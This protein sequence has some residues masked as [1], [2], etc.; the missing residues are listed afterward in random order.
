MVAP[1]PGR[2]QDRYVGYLQLL[3]LSLP[4]LGGSP[5]ST[6]DAPERGVQGRR[7]AILETEAVDAQSFILRAC[8]PVPRGV[9]PREDGQSPF[10]LLDGPGGKAVPTQVA[11]VSRA[12]DGQADVLEV[13]ARVS[14]S[15]A[16]LQLPDV[17]PGRGRPAAPRQRFTLLRSPTPTAPGPALPATVEQLLLPRGD[18]PLRLRARDPI[19]H[20]YELNLR[21]S[22]LDAGFGGRRVLKSGRYLRQTRTYGSLVCEQPRRPKGRLASLPSPLPHL[23]G[24]HAYIT[25]YADEERVSL[26]LRIHNGHSPG[27]GK[28]Q[29]LEEPLGLVYFESLEL[30]LPAGWTALP[31]V[32]DPFWGTPRQ[33][34]D[35]VVIPLVAPMAP[36][37]DGPPAMHM[38]GPRGLFTRRLELVPCAPNQ[39]DTKRPTADAA[40]GLAFP[41]SRADL[42]CWQNLDTANFGPQRT[43]LAD[44][45]FYRH[46]D[47]HGAAGARRADSEALAALVDLLTSGAAPEG[48][49]DSESASVMGWAH[50]WFKKYQ[51]V[52][53]GFAIDTIGGARVA[54]SA[55]QA[56][57]SRLEL[58]HR[59]NTCRQPQALYDW[60][61]EPAGYRQWVDG[62]G[63]VAQKYRTNVLGSPPRQRLPCLGG[64][65]AS[66]QAKTA[67]QAG[68]RPNY[69]LGTAA[70]EGGRIE[71]S[72]GSLLAW[73]PHDGQHLAR[74]TKFAQ[75]LAWLGN[76]A[77]AKDDLLLCAELYRLM[78]HEGL[79][80]ERVALAAA[81]PERAAPGELTGQDAKADPELAGDEAAR[82]EPG[83]E[84]AAAGNAPPELTPRERKLQAKRAAKEAELE[85]RRTKRERQNTRHLDQLPA[86][87]GPPPLPVYEL[88][89]LARERRQ[90]GAQVGRELAWGLDAMCAAYSLGTPD[91]RRGSAG[92]FQRMGSVLPGLAMPNGLIQR[93]VSRKFFP[94]PDHAGAQ[95]FEALLL[96]HGM[97]CLDASVFDTVAANHSEALRT[98]ALRAVDYLFFGPPWQLSAK[99]DKRGPARAFA[100]APADAREPAYGPHESGADWALPE[101][102]VAPEVETLYGYEALAWAAQLSGP[103]QG[104]ALQNR[105]LLRALKYG[106]GAAE[107]QALA[108]TLAQRARSPVRDDSGNWAGFLGYLQALGRR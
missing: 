15:Q 31:R 37:A 44:W 108:A 39:L 90:G 32:R 28:A 105:Y 43:V 3:A 98:T 53:G 49:S 95:S 35:E 99:G 68:R 85:A 69:D 40:R 94:N 59:M 26:D 8:V 97:R 74:Y 80:P 21:G 30:V 18:N 70:M 38:I 14:G 67:I 73:M 93:Q 45:S 54:G 19:G 107:Y 24:V 77:L 79:D 61:G 66:I 7:V 56:G 46:G 106:A 22:E 23:F 34:G 29:A 11:I 50:P 52:T 84:D 16:R 47:Q 36:P 89:A 81:G 25:E 10:H 87:P 78:V 57:Y 41:V 55:S 48:A 2:G 9:Y 42:W 17:L 72:A 64:P 103:E 27:A 60:R 51:G 62:M 65:A 71:A 13:M 91:W 96:V 76:D 102:A 88:E 1:D 58:L 92:W 12:P 75:A 20:P 6:Q 100:V 63:Q 104:S 83:R 33:E 4:L 86:K 5:G 82:V 101:D